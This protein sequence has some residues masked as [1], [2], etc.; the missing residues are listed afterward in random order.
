MS[1]RDGDYWVPKRNHE[2]L[3]GNL[4]GQE[5]DV[6]GGPVVG[7]REGAVVLDC[8]ANVGVY[9]RKALLARAARVI[10][11]EPAPENVECLRR[12]FAEEIRTGKV[13]VRPAGVWNEAAELPLNIDAGSSARNSFVGTFGP[14]AGVVKVPLVTIDSIIEGLSMDKIDF[15]K[16]D[17]EGAEKRAI[18]GT[19]LTLRKFHPR[20]AIA[21]EHLDDDPDAIPAAIDAMDLGYR[22]VCGPCLDAKTQVTPDV[23]YFV[24]N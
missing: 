8:G 17:I 10:A 14:V 7:V 16:L 20:L 19:A 23:L 3:F 22:I 6:Y 13:I 11:V 9:T 15:I 4:A 24:P 18:A 12:N 5:Q 1:T 21:M 2:T